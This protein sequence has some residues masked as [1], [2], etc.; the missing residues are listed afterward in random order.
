MQKRR[1]ILDYAS[2]S[3]SEDNEPASINNTTRGYEFNESDDD[4]ADSA[5]EDL[6]K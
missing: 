4:S 2:D 1:R 6:L 5:P 3:S